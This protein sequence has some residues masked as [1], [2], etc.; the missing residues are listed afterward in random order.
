M[1]MTDGKETIEIIARDTTGTDISTSYFHAETMQHDPGTDS[2]T[3]PDIQPYKGM[4]SDQGIEI[5]ISRYGNHTPA[6]ARR[7]DEELQARI[8]AAGLTDEDLKELSGL[9]QRHL[10]EMAW[11]RMSE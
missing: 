5:K 7:I 4:K 8:K 3:V 1:L 10:N 6:E 11:Q 9:K 2:Y